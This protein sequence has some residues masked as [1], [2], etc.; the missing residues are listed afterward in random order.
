[1]KYS[2]SDLLRNFMDFI[3]E[4]C[5]LLLDEYDE[6]YS[7]LTETLD[8]IS[9]SPK[10]KTKFETLFLEIGGDEIYEKIITG[11]DFETIFRNVLSSS[12]VKL[13]QLMTDAMDS[14]FAEIRERKISIQRFM[15][16][17]LRVEDEERE[18]RRWPLP[19]RQAKDAP[20]DEKVFLHAYNSNLYESI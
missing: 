19:H 5:Q 17:H 6:F 9:G 12:L 11:E 13:A 1:M 7:S 4:K 2:I 14:R 8:A 18:I 15:N 16:Q 10:L 20:N 3:S